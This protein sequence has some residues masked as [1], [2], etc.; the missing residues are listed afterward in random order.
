MLLSP[1]C[2]LLVIP[3]FARLVMQTRPVAAAEPLPQA[4]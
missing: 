3:A 1:I 4:H 2:S